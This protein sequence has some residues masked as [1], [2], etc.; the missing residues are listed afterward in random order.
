MTGPPRGPA[1]RARAVPRPPDQPAGAKL[2]DR[3]SGQLA[4]EL[5]R[6]VQFSRGLRAAP[7][8]QRRRSL[9]AE[10]G[11]RCTH[12]THLPHAHSEVLLRRGA[13][14]EE[15]YQLLGA[16]Q[17]VRRPLQHVHRLVPQVLSELRMGLDELRLG[18]L[19]RQLLHTNN[20][21][22]ARGG[23]GT[24][25]SIRTWAKSITRPPF[26]RDIMTRA[27]WPWRH[28]GRSGAAHRGSCCQAQPP[29]RVSTRPPSR[30]ATHSCQSAFC[31]FRPFR[32]SLPQPLRALEHCCCAA[33]PLSATLDTAPS[34]L[35]GH[36]RFRILTDST[37]A[38]RYCTSRLGCQLHVGLGHCFSLGC[39]S[40]GQAHV[41]PQAP[42]G[43]CRRLQGPWPPARQD[44][45]CA[46]SVKKYP[47]LRPGSPFFTGKSG[48]G[49]VGIGFGMARGGG[50]IG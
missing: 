14:S 36:L 31:Q 13:F 11:G 42:N 23:G 32:P 39:N 17:A 21:S 43:P 8:R 12:Q 10:K 7:D 9:L 47:V 22:Q 50:K 29:P 24:L 1:I 27:A 34:Q 33:L 26:A 20:V 4:A 6:D 25:S 16:R 2:A 44:R 5:I 3:L 46:I 19:R 15:H 38:T 35:C 41:A 45:G 37:A 30:G 28:G 40:R 49:V 18:S 48:F